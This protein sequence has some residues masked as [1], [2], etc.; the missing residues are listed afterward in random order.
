MGG[1]I[2][3]TL[4]IRGYSECNR[5][6]YFLKQTRLCAHTIQLANI[7]RHVYKKMRRAVTTQ[8]QSCYAN[9]FSKEP[10]LCPSENLG[11]R[12]HKNESGQTLL[13]SDWREVSDRFSRDTASAPCFRGV[14]IARRDTEIIQ[15][16]LYACRGTFRNNSYSSNKYSTA[17]VNAT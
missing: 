10:R 7:Q 12:A 14:V 5:E 3:K 11:R 15:V 6:N 2:N 13:C 16:E 1:N 4:T 17:I 9:G 8:R